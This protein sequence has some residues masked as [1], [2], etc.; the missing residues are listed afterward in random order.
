[1]DEP[2]F[3]CAICATRPYGGTRQFVLGYGVSIW[4]CVE[5]GSF[6]FQRLHGG[7]AFAEALERVW[8]ANGCLTAA[9]IRALEGHVRA[10]DPAEP[11]RPRP[12]SYTWPALRDEAERRFAAGERLQ[13]AID[14]RRDIAA[15]SGANPPSERTLRRWYA[16][17]R[18][19][20][21]PD[22]TGEP[23]AREAP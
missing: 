4:L 5:H 7:R 3:D 12:G 9:R 17:R 6:P 8:A 23:A 10:L 14:A 16:E 11:V 1:M 2:G 21:S 13:P 20:T 19:L 15:G 18:W 22:R